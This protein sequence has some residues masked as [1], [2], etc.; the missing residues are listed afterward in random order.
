MQTQ[1]I[2]F[3]IILMALTMTTCCSSASADLV[4]VVNHGFEDTTG[5]GTFN[6]FTFGV[7]VGWSIYD[8]DGALGPGFFTG[9]L[10]P[11]GVNFFNGPAPEG[12]RVAI[13]FNSQGE[14]TGEY[15]YEQTLSTILTAN[16]HY[17]LSVSVGNI[18]S[19]F[20]QDGTFFDLSE[21]PGYRIDLLAGGQVIAQDLNSLSIAEGEFSTSTVEFTTGAFHALLGQNLGIRLV[22]LNI[23]PNGFTQ[24]TSPDLE[25]DFDNVQLNAT[26]IPEPA[27]SL[28]MCVLAMTCLLRRTRRKPHYA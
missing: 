12:D 5:Q 3:G 28:A 14:G 6:E 24:A 19:G 20:A 18:T 13:L 9:T 2:A 23:I 27:T 11:D 4:D 21:F 10:L 15:G 7:P 22:N 8:P 25:V 1:L 26:S 17:S 16:T